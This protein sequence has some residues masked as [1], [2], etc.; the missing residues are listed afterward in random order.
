MSSLASCRPNATTSEFN[1]WAAYSGLLRPKVAQGGPRWLN[2]GGPKR[3]K[4]AHARVAR[5]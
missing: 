5:A 3:L 1:F 2:K 4:V